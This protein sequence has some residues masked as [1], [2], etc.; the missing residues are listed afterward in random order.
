M[1]KYLLLLINAILFIP[2]YSFASRLDIYFEGNLLVLGCRLS[3]NDTKKEIYLSELRLFSLDNQ[4]RS[5]TQYF[6]I[7]IV[8][9]SKVALDKMI[10]ITFNSQNI[11][12]HNN[13]DYLTTTGNSNVLLSL[14]D[15]ENKEIKFNTP[16]DTNKV[17]ESGKGSSNILTFGVYA[18]K[19]F[20][21][22]L[23]TGSFSSIV[24]FS[25]DYQ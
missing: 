1:I 22:F 7:N 16:I 11:E 23:N 3:D 13:I 4:G 17:I 6:Q 25:L 24:T 8:D 9:C 18:Q 5:D 21:N 20:N 2:N 19:P 15:S 10:K 14:T 12:T